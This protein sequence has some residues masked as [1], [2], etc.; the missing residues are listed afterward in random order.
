MIFL[1]LGRLK[2]G[3][4][5]NYF[6]NGIELIKSNLIK[7]AHPHLLIDKVIKKYLNYKFSSKRN[8]LK[9]TSDVHYFK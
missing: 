2:I 8:Q 9:G 5:S 7:N 3:D 6:Y 1:K 4:N